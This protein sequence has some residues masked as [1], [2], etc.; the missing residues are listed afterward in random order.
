MLGDTHD[1]GL[2]PL[3]A[4]L[5]EPVTRISEEVN[6]VAEVVYEDRLADVQF[7]IAARAGRRDGHVIAEDLHRDHDHGLALRGVDFPG[8]DRATG[9]VLGQ[10]QFAQSRTRT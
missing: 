5:P 6:G 10:Y 1:V 9:L 4:E 2:E 8:H 7:E 3:D